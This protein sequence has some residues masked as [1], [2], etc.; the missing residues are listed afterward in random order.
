MTYEELRRLAK[1]TNW[2]KSR[3]L[4]TLLKKAMELIEEDDFL[5]SYVKH[6]FNDENEELEIYIL[7]AKEKIF[8]SKYLYDAKST[9]VTVYDLADMEQIRLTEAADGEKELLILFSYG[10][11]IRL[12]SQ[13]NYDPEHKNFIVEFARDIINM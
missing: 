12:N 8:V 6:L 11:D 10:A 9:Q 2:E 4:F 3:L 5:N 13:E 1:Q 7:S